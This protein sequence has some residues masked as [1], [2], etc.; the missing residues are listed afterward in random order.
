LFVGPF[1]VG[2]TAD[3][4]QLYFTPTVCRT[5]KKCPVEFIPASDSSAF[6]VVSEGDKKTVYNAGGQKL[7][8][9]KYDH[10]QYAGAGI[11]IVVRNDKKGLVS[12]NGKELLPFDFDAIGS[13]TNKSIS[14]LSKLKFGLYDVAHH[15]QIKPQYEKNLIHYDDKLL[16]CFKNGQFGFVDWNNKPVGKFEFDEIRYWNDTTAFV[17]KEFQWKLYSIYKEKVVIDHIKKFNVVSDTGEE[18]IFILNVENDFGIV[19]NKRGTIL[20][21]TFTGIRN[22]GSAD[23]PLYFTEKHIEEASVFIVIYYDKNGVLIR[24][25]I[26]DEEDY[27]KIYCADE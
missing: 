19:S 21:F 27:E 9:G 26:Y 24:K 7:F 3:S 17:R 22:M 4:L 15:R 11:F 1:L 6:L 25:E 14:L 16:V 5:L 10:V 8:V 2:Y 18:K 20:P 23:N 13:V 12:Y